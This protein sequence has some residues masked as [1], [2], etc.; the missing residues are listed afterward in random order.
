MEQAA[1]NCGLSLY[2]LK[3]PVMEER[4]ELTEEF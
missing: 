4:K 1:S 3:L 2:S